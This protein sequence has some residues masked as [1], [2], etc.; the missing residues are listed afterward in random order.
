MNEIIKLKKV[1]KM[2]GKR[3]VISDISLNIAEKE[4]IAFGGEGC[5]MLMQIMCG[6][7][8]PSSG[9]VFVVGKAIHELSDAQAAEFRNQNIGIVRSDAAL[10]RSYSVIENVSLP[11]T[12]RK[13][14]DKQRKKAAKNLLE[15]LGIS[16]ISHA[17]PN[18]I[19]ELEQRLTMLAQALVT[20]PKVLMLKDILSGL[21]ER[22]TE[23]MSGILNAI[24]GFGD[25]TVL[26]F[27]TAQIPS[28]DKTFVI[29]YGK[30]LEGKR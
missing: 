2:T 4:H 27:D 30:I 14:P 7:Q 24:S 17:L 23:K 25:Y 18:M 9:E 3:R 26:N 19:S 29:R 28:A 21:N 11:L 12:I 22:E 20:Q 8:A 16:Q 10:F 15:E 13:E 6:M 1:I 5:Y